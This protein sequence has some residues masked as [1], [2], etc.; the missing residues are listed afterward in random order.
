MTQQQ[1]DALIEY[2]NK[3]V[4]LSERRCDPDAVLAAHQR[5]ERA[6]VTEGK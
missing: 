2:I 3:K 4:A 1:F 5:A 6:C